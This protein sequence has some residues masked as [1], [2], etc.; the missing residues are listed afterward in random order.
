M[1]ASL[2]CWQNS[3]PILC[4]VC[5]IKIDD[6]RIYYM[7]YDPSLFDHNRS[8]FY[9]HRFHGESCRSKLPVLIFSKS[10]KQGIF[11]RQ[12]SPLRKKGFTSLFTDLLVLSELFILDH[13]T[14]IGTQYE[15]IQQW[16]LSDHK[17]SFSKILQSKVG[18][19]SPV[20]FS[21]TP[22]AKWSSPFWGT[23]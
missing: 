20:R 4:K 8:C 15:D 22:L 12:N 9:S 17:W 14:L 3:T 13:W 7:L 1:I 5:T 16:S 11:V 21:T 2:N 18:H 10:R 23:L 6:V 19:K